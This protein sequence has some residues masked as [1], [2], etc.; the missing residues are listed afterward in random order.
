MKK[1]KLILFVLIMV[2]NGVSAQKSISIEKLRCEYLK[3]PIGL[4]TEYPR[5]SW[6]LKS[7]T[8]NQSQQAYQILAASHPTLLSDKKA[9]LWNSGKVV[10]D[11][12]IQLIYNG[13]ELKSRSKVYWKVRVWDKDG[14]A[15]KWSDIAQFELGL[16]TP[17][18]WKANWIKTDL[19]FDEYRY[20]A[21]RFRK[22]FNLEKKIEK[23]RVYVSSLGMYEMF[24]NGQRVGDDYLTPGWT[25]YDKR[26]QYQV[27]DITNL[28]QA[29]NSLGVQLGNGWYR[30]FRYWKNNEEEQSRQDLALIAQIEVSYT[31]GTKEVILTDESW[32]SNVSP[33]Q[34]S[35]IYNGEL[36]DARMEDADWNSINF[37]S[38]DW[39]G[40]EIVSAQKDILVA[41]I[42]PPVKKIDALKPIAVIY[43]PEGDTVLDMGQNMVGW[44]KLRVSEKQGT[45]I[46]LRHAEVLDKEGN[47]YTASLRSAKQTVEYICKGGGIETY[48]P[49]FTFQGF[50]YVAVS[51]VTNLNPD[52]FTGVVLHTDMDRT[53]SFSCNDS[54]INQLQSNIL[55][56]QKGN[57]VDVPTDCPQRD[58][59]LGWTGDTQV[60]GPTACFNMSSAGFYTKWLRDLAADQHTNGTVP[61]VI[62]DKLGNGKS[63]GGAFGWADAAIIVPWT[64]Y[65]WYGDKRILEEQ[66]ESMKKWEEF[67]RKEAGDNYLY[68]PRVRQFGDWLAYATTKS[69]YPGATTEKDLLASD[70]FFYSTTLMAKIATI[71]GKEGDASQ[72][73]TLAQNIKQAHNKEF[74]SQNGRLT[75]N[76]QTAYVVGLSFGIIPEEQEAIAAKRL[77][78]D[79]NKFG[80]ITTGF[81]GT[82][83]ICH[84]LTKYGYLDE[85]YK[86][87]YRKEYPSWL[88]PI[89]KGATTIWERWDGI[90]ADDTFQ[91]TGMNSFNHYAY[92][93]IGSWLYQKVAGIDFDSEQPAFKQFRI[94]PYPGGKMNDVK[95][96]HESLYGTISSEWTIENGIFQLK[97]IVPVNTSAEIYVPATD[98]HLSKDGKPARGIETINQD[99]LK[100]HFNKVKVGSGTYLFESSFKIN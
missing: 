72:Y 55:W 14:R 82:P 86:L 1:S 85:A 58:E 71:I 63:G 69:D 36:Y 78:D 29:K 10:S 8:N 39:A 76:T 16:L 92:G 13:V 97:V 84:V 98:E 34:M 57:F 24:I 68:Q 21:L 100:Y 54:L 12:S 15:S 51:G 42:A 49:H 61:H 94:K 45:R 66:Y 5:L 4:G 9:D 35:E 62:P 28:L 33:I 2:V 96:S 23:A 19:V 22:E 27:Y 91:S 99:G 87:M 53:G 93:A 64:V 75:S 31:D 56:G 6:L 77:A 74:I 17:K 46:T 26:V 43:T 11:Q 52:D 25:S 3:D 18:D 70:Y 89:S 30:A 80:H 48:E 32:E 47:L 50:R 38:N 73:K 79:V 65:Q 40:T 59:R 20:P 44:M 7:D 60:F 95:A 41:A 37:D 83:D 88:Y 81:L 90:K 67:M